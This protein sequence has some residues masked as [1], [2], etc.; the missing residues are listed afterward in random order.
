VDVKEGLA[1][2]DF[3]QPLL[4]IGKEAVGV[5]S[6]LVQGVLRRPLCLLSGQGWVGGPD[7]GG[8][9][10]AHFGD[11]LHGLMVRPG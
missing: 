7:G 10:L 4:G 2:L 11:N 8:D 3:I 6:G 5:G 1:V 9:P